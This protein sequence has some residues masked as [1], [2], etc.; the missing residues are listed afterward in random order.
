MSL[1][2]NQVAASILTSCGFEIE[3]EPEWVTG[4]KPDF[5]C[6]GPCDLW[7]EVKSVTTDKRFKKLGEKFDDLCDRAKKVRMT[8]FAHAWVADE[9]TEFHN[10]RALTLAI[11][12]LKIL[13][14]NP[15]GY[16]R[17]CV[18]VPRDPDPKRDVRLEFRTSAGQ[19]LLVCARSAKC[20]YG[21]PISEDEPRWDERRVSVDDEVSTTN[22]DFYELG[23][24]DDDFLVGLEIC[25]GSDQ[26]HIVSAAPQGVARQI[27]TTETV[28]LAATKANSQFK[29]ACEH[30]AAP[31]LLMV[32]EDGL[33]V[34]D[35]RS[36]SAVFLGDLAYQFPMKEFQNGRLVFARN[37]IWNAG[38]LTTMS[39]SALVCNNSAPILLRNPWALR[40]LPHDALPWPS[41]AI[42]AD[43]AVTFP[44]K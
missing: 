24:A 13:Q 44:T 22:A 32:F 14:L 34:Q 18:I 38:A 1:A 40:P 41:V 3:P 17:V 16:S 9:A 4:Q 27:T 15:N 36:F 6:H 29:S 20:H 25:A 35:V 26:F 21:R 19:E 11:E 39:A 12:A 30:R 42:D 23:L 33:G 31:C 5:F 28:R 8:G 43:G 2:A 37:G 10:K 7:V